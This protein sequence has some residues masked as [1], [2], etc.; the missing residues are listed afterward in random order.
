MMSEWQLIETVPETV[1]KDGTVILVINEAQGYAYPAC[2]V[3]SHGWTDPSW[4]G[5]YD[6]THWMEHPTPPNGRTL[7]KGTAALGEGSK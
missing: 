7:E 4:D 5:C 3:P 6:P 2:W 1:L